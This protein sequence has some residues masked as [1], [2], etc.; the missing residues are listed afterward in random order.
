MGKLL[1]LCY[2]AFLTYVNGYVLTLQK[3][4]RLT[5]D[6]IFIFVNLAQ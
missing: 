6:F 1:A 5:I 4:A 3:A 2:C